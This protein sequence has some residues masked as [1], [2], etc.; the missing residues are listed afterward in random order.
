VNDI[1][2]G[3][4]KD[5]VEPTTQ[6]YWDGEGWLGNPL[7]ADDTPPAGPPAG[8][9]APPAPPRVTPT[10]VASPP[11][12]PVRHPP[13]DVP[14][15]G[16]PP[17]GPPPMG[18]PPAGPPPMGRPP[19][20]PPPTMTPELPPGW[21]LGVPG[22]GRRPVPRPHDMRLAN[23]GSRLVARIVD[24]LAVLVLAVVANAWIAREFWAQAGP[25]LRQ[26]QDA[27]NGGTQPDDTQLSYLVLAMFAITAAVWFA[28]EVPSTAN[29]G[30]TL[31]KKLLG[32]K[33][34]RVE[35]PDRLGMGRSWRRWSPMGIP[36]L[37]WSCLGVGFLLQFL[38]CLF[39]AI[40]R[41]LHQAWHDK[42][43]ATVVVEVPRPRKTP[44]ENATSGGQDAHPR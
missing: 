26:L 44:L 37:L 5:P 31:G 3:W 30:Q 2:P 20:G 8:V 28:Y 39:V 14:P 27:T 18:P 7:P 24:V 36:V 41:P 1:A 10:P 15:Y 43:A 12:M 40:D 38:D 16:Q 11:A 34:V 32:I 9:A 4:Y 25:Y 22:Y 17:M 21:T 6:R 29:S 13:T 19:T 23:I 35:S 33:V 42:S